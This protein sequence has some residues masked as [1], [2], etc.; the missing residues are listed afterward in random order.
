MFIARWHALCACAASACLV[1]APGHCAARAPGALRDFLRAP[2]G[3]TAAP[4]YGW[5]ADAYRP[6]NVWAFSAFLA[7]LFLCASIVFSPACGPLVMQADGLHISPWRRTGPR[8][9]PAPSLPERGRAEAPAGR[10]GPGRG[11]TELFWNAPPPARPAGP[12]HRGAGQPR[13]R[14]ARRGSGARWRDRD[15]WGGGG[16]VSRAF[17]LAFPSHFLPARTR[18]PGTGPAR[19]GLCLPDGGRLPRYGSSASKSRLRPWSG[20]VSAPWSALVSTRART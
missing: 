1:S 15:A 10:A 9:R 14:R 2:P 6:G 4:A 8:R 17:G 3:R 13:H 19:A 11:R 5:R 16:G 20:L 7:C 12:P 18:G